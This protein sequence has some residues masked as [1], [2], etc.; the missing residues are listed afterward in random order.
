MFC[1]LTLPF[2]DWSPLMDVQAED[3]THRIGQTRP[4]TVHRLYTC[5]TIEVHMSDLARGKLGMAT[6]LMKL[7][8]RAV[9][10]GDPE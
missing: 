4:V 5:G 9:V 3:R 10:S 6:A 8:E 7:S 2:V 1:T